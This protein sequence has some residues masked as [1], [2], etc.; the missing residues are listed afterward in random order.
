MSNPY[1]TIIKSVKLQPGEQFILPPGAKL[2]S[3]SNSDAISSSCGIDDLEQFSCYVFPVAVAGVEGSE[4][5]LYEGQNVK[6]LG[7]NNNGVLQPIKNLSNQ[8]YYAANADDGDF[9][10]G[11]LD[12]L[13]GI[14]NVPI[15]FDC[16][17]GYVGASVITNDPTDRGKITFIY[18][19]TVPSYA[20]KILLE[21]QSSA[22]LGTHR[23]DVSF[24]VKPIPYDKFVSSDYLDQDLCECAS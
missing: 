3:A 15:T 11:L 23:S 1:T 4:S 9:G 14:Q 22:P 12:A 19:R 21:V 5:Q 6:I 2:I 7:I 24:F 18:F 16:V 10:S 13:K 8:P 17:G 20:D